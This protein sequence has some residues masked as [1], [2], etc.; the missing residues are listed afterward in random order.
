MMLAMM[1]VKSTA[2]GIAEERIEAAVPVYSVLSID[3]MQN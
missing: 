1:W 3:L 2:Y